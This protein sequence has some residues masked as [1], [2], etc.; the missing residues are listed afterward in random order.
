[1]KFFSPFFAPFF[2]AVAGLSLCPASNLPAATPFLETTDLFVAANGDY[3]HIPGIVVTSKGTVLA[4]AAWREH[5]T[6]DWGNIKV[7]LRRSTDGGKTWDAAHQ[8]AP[9]GKAPKAIVLSSPPKVK[10]REKEIT[11]D[12]GV[13]IPDRNGAVHMLYCVEYRRVFYSRSDDDGLTWSKPTEISKIFEKYRPEIN[14]K[15]VATGPGHGIQLN[16][17]RLEVPVWLATGGKE[18]Y[19]HNPS[20]VGVTFSDDH[21]KTWQTGDIVSRTT[22]RGTDPII[23]HNPNETEAVQLADGSVLF[24]M[25]T[26]SAHQRKMTSISLNGATGWCKPQFVEDLP[27]P[28]NFGSTR[29]LSLKPVSDK[30]RLLFSITGSLETRAEKAPD[31]KSCKREDMTVFLSYDEG[32][33]WPVKKIIRPGTAGCGYSDLAVLPDGTIL[34]AYGAG[35]KFGSDAKIVLTRF[36]LEWLTDGKDSVP[37]GTAD[38]GVEQA[39]KSSVAPK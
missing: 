4:Y 8:I 27:E 13:L 23:Y 26:P 3:Y 11:V 19:Q 16:N 7:H 20:M 15:I 24:N 34:C 39:S 10:G 22:G 31:E 36:N 33:T 25:R 12:N 32:K 37:L 14:W 35:P 6:H 29:R 18:G 30:N 5:D 21:G 38:P 17:G 2:L 1:M 28:V 9:Q